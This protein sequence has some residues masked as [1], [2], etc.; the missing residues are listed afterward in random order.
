[1]N[2]DGLE[3]LTESERAV[4]RELLRHGHQGSVAQALNLSPETVKTH[5]RNAR[6]KC[7]ASASFALARLLDESER[8]TPKRVMPPFGG[9]TVTPQPATSGTSEPETRNGMGDEVREERVAFGFQGMPMPIVDEHRDTGTPGSGALKRL[10][11]AGALV[12]IVT[13]AIILA[14]PLS[15][16]FQRLANVV[17]PP[18]H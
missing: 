5:L 16:S 6:E 4:L 1:M 7:G 2:L 13:L 3:R 17:A 14:F 10:L 8:S 18:N 9:G 11:T 12:L 15:E